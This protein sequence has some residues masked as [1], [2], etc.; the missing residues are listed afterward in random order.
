MIYFHFYIRAGKLMKASEYKN[1][2]DQNLNGNLTMAKTEKHPEKPCFSKLT[3]EEIILGLWRLF[4]I[5]C[6]TVGDSKSVL[7]NN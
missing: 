4:Y 7:E 3:S 2:D 1:C 6:I 5:W